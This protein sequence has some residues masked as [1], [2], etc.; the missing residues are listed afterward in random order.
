MTIL[1]KLLKRDPTK[2]FV[3]DFLTDVIEPHLEEI[4]HRKIKLVAN[5][6]G[7]IPDGLRL[8][9][10]EIASKK[11]LKVKIVTVKGDDLLAQKILPPHIVSM[12]GIETETKNFISANAYLGAAPV[13]QALDLGAD[14]VISAALETSHW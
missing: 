1:A 9:I 12:N 11:K 4:L 5:A 3:P 2:G 14:I 10:E 8:A 13:A 7:L 6:G